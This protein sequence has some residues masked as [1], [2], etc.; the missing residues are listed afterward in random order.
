MAFISVSETRL[1]CRRPVIGTVEQAADRN[2]QLAKA[3][4]WSF[5][6]T[7]GEKEER[8]IR[9][10]AGGVPAVGARGC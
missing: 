5:I 10:A 9:A 4:F 8:R 7:V 2:K 1:S 3:K 6:Y